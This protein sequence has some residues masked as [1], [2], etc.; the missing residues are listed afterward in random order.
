MGGIIRIF[1]IDNGRRETFSFRLDAFVSYNIDTHLLTLV[2]GSVYVHHDSEERVIR[3]YRLLDEDGIEDMGKYY[4]EF[5]RLKEENLA[6]R[7]EIA[8]NEKHGFFKRWRK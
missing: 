7:K 1:I 2:N 8:E 3:A 6:I 5:D 4:E